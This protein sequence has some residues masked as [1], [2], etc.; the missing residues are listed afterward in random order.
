MRVIEFWPD[1][2]PGPLWLDG[3]AVAPDTLGITGDL[4][5]RLNAWHAAYEESK[6]PVDGPGDPAWLGEGTQLLRD[7]RRAVAPGVEIV[8]TEPW[9]GDDPQR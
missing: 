6:V 7:I 1:Y 4:A 3:R 2:G 5:S 9:W 8:V